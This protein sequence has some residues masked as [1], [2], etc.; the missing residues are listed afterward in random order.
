MGIRI[1]TGTTTMKE[2]CENCK[3]YHSEGNYFRHIKQGR[4][5]RF[6][7]QGLLEGYEYGSKIKNGNEDYWQYPLMKA[8]DTCGEFTTKD[9]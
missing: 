9:A 6:P 7:K 5:K 8:E 1:T 3:Y 4:C 2:H